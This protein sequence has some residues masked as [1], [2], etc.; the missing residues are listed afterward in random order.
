[1]NAA[2][3]AS[4]LEQT[5]LAQSIQSGLNTFP[6]LEVVHVVALALVVGSIF[7]VDL[8]LM[9]FASRTYRVSDLTKA[10]LP[11]TVGAF[12]VAFISGSLMFISQAERYLQTTPFLIKMGLLVLAAVN[13]AVFHLWSHRGVVEWDVGIPPARAVRRLQLDGIVG[14]HPLCRPLCRLHAADVSPRRG[15]RAGIVNDAQRHLKWSKAS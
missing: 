7:I 14:C 10:M 9:N 4:A 15:E 13:M 3:W 1:M 5:A 2:S 6:M 12:V 11:I 8:R